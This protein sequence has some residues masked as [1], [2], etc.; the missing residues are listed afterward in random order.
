MRYTIETSNTIAGS[1]LVG[2]YDTLA[3]AKFAAK[4][5]R[6]QIRPIFTA[7]LDQITTPAT[8]DGLQTLLDN[9]E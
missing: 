4:S 9:I 7:S 2:I 1:V 6:C 3:E 5:H 8:L